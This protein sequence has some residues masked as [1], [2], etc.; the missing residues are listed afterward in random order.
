MA[1]ISG[2]CLLY[3]NATCNETVGTSSEFISIL[4]SELYG[5]RQFLLHIVC[6]W[7]LITWRFVEPQHSC[8]SELPMYLQKTGHCVESLLSFDVICIFV[9][10]YCTC[11][12]VIYYVIIFLHY[13]FHSVLVDA[14]YMVLVLC[15]KFF[16]TFTVTYSEKVQKFASM[17]W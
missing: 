9:I 1:C 11:Q 15:V 16:A 10:S 3:F 6:L 12:S 5:S 7:V 13:R 8:C 4:P 17:C 2:F 14:F